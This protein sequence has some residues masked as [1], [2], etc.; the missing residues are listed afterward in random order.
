MAYYRQM[1]DIDTA[2]VLHR[3]RKSVWPVKNQFLRDIKS[4]GDLYGPFWICATLVFT[5]AMCGNLAHYKKAA[6]PADWHYDFSKCALGE[7]CQLPRSLDA[8]G[9]ACPVLF[10]S[11]PL[12][13][14]VV[15]PW[16]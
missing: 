11:H 9:V 2:Q 4:R 5:M 12:F 6:D 10:L 14:A 7:A 16:I 8:A 3:I 1:F 15:V 13:V